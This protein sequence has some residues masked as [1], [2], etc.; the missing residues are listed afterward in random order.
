MKK[1]LCL[2]AILLCLGAQ[3]AG[4]EEDT[5]KV[6]I[7]ENP[8]APLPSEKAKKIAFLN[9]EVFI[10]DNIYQGSIKVSKDENGLHFINEL[11]FE[12]YIEGVVA[13]ETAPNW[14]LE[15]LKVQAVISRT[16]AIY[17]KL[18]TAGKDYHITSSVLHQVYKGSNTNKIIRQA[19][20]E[21]SGEFLAYDGKPIE[22]FYHST[23]QGKTEYPDAVW[24]KSYPYLQSVPCRGEHSPYE[25]WQRRFS[26]D[27][28]EQ[29]LGLKGIKGLDIT[30]H[31]STGRVEFLKVTAEDL[32]I[33]I[34][35]IDL[36]KLLGYRELPS[37]DFTVTI[38]EANVIFEGGGYGH[39]VGL[40]Q[41][42]SLELANE[43]KNY[44]EILE[45]YYPGTVLEKQS[46]K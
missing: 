36:R 13:A 39:G 38:E 45:H 30:S 3:N 41:W 19:V 31:T 4:A 16:Y 28:L 7:I 23:C 33:E 2:A 25:H 17:Q 5:I 37:T 10:N 44:K 11:P 20:Q 46:T 24:G 42:G 43:G 9:G 35:A 21:T 12:E 32:E 22:A 14:T 18:L 8:H 15:A 6:L 26:I 1:L 29:A 34:K 40:S 27:E